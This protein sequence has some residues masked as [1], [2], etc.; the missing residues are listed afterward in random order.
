MGLIFTIGI[1]NFG[2]EKC[3]ECEEC[4]LDEYYIKYAVGVQAN[5]YKVPIDIVIRNEHDK[6]TPYSDTDSWNITLG[7]VKKGFTASIWVEFGHTFLGDAT[8]IAKIYVSKNDSPFALK[9]E[10]ESADTNEPVQI[11]YTIDY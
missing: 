6:T 4:D 10:A 8:L 7:P 11:D 9:E 2:C 5:S 1:I 3:E